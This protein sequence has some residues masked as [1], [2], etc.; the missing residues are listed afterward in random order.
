MFT[1][2]LGSFTNNNTNTSTSW[3]V[4]NSTGILD[5]TASS[6]KNVTFYAN[7][8]L[9]G[10]LKCGTFTIN[11]SKT[12]T[13][14]G[15]VYCNSNAVITGTL[16][17]NAGGK[18]S[19]TGTG[20]TSTGTIIGTGTINNSGTLIT[21]NDIGVKVL[22]NINA[23]IINIC[24][25]TSHDF[26]S[27]NNLTKTTIVIG[28]GNHVSAC[29][30][31]KNNDIVVQKITFNNSGSGTCYL[32]SANCTV[33][34]LDIGSTSGSTGCKVS[35]EPLYTLFIEGPQVSNANHGNVFP[36][37]GT[38]CYYSGKSGTWAVGN[39]TVMTISTTGTY[40]VTY[41][42]N[43]QICANGN[44]ITFG[45][46]IF[47]VTKTTTIKGNLEIFST[48]SGGTVTTNDYSD[49]IITV[50]SSSSNAGN[51][52]FTQDRYNNFVNPFILNL[53][54]RIEKNTGGTYPATVY[55]GNA[56]ST[57]NVYYE[58]A[59]Y[60]AINYFTKDYTTL[61][62]S[63]S[64]FYGI[65]YYLGTTTGTNQI[66][67]PVSYYDMTVNRT[68]SAHI[69]QLKNYSIAVRNDLTMTQGLVDVNDLNID[70]LTTGEIIDESNT[71]RIYCSGCA[72]S[73]AEGRILSQ[74]T[75]LAATTNYTNIRGMGI[76]ITTYAN[77]PGSTDINRGFRIRSGGELN[78]SVKRYF[79]I[80][81]TNNTTLGATL[82]FHYWDLESNG[83]SISEVALYRDNTGSDGWVKRGGSYAAPVPGDNTVTLPGIDEFSPWT[84]GKNNEPVPVRLLFFDATCDKNKI[85]L[86]WSTASETNC[87]NFI[88]EKSYD[89]KTWTSIGTLAGA[90]NSNHLN[91]YSFSDDEPFEK[92]VYYRLKQ[93][94][95]D[96]AFDIYGPVAAGCA[97]NND[98]MEIQ[99]YPN[100][101]DEKVYIQAA[102]DRPGNIL[103]TDITGR[104]ITEYQQHI[105]S[106][107]LE[108][109]LES[110]PP[111][112]Y[113][114][115]VVTEGFSNNYKIVRK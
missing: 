79:E 72:S 35:V 92:T 36:G 111:G 65:V 61:I 6:N 104:T 77:A 7:T 27:G 90:G 112:I 66:A 99:V 19:T 87:D 102:I 43:L 98:N 44:S 96:G 85:V 23:N 80:T 4:L 62:S 110:V 15:I 113:M 57:I 37:T 8:T 54:N 81:P 50:G 74:G 67:I 11:S 89:T 46:N 28:D 84:V 105:L 68:N 1:Y 10:T 49:R 93:V 55:M 17:I 64:P 24:G 45:N 76:G 107:P 9:S 38:V 22:G 106:V 75:D 30:W 2:C 109:S 56:S 3:L 73:L 63:L 60:P 91:N 14:G 32:S 34:D 51:F 5:L 100:P 103:L 40:N 70:L 83:L 101:T 13:V 18:F 78:T 20:G 71:N 97:E 53:N 115:R 59:T 52:Y 108:V 94:D 26:K 48:A 12:A 95:Y 25:G 31:L 41:G 114:I 21:G 58:N 69:V 42:G 82:T 29:M 33:Y 16:T 86:N 47:T 39:Q 88:I